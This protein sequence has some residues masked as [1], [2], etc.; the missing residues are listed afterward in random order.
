MASL[1]QP[2]ERIT[3]APERDLI[4]GWL[5]L[6][7]IAAEKQSHIPGR[8]EPIRC[9]NSNRRRRRDRRLSLHTQLHSFQTRT[10]E[11]L[12]STAACIR[13]RGRGGAAATRRDLNVHKYE[14]HVAPL[15]CLVIFLWACRCWSGGRSLPEGRRG[16][17]KSGSPLEVARLRRRSR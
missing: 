9:L 2:D 6:G 11:D 7:T 5:V 10:G 15:L 4:M 13:A 3:A 8:E 17:L 16:L 12:K 1:L 14:E